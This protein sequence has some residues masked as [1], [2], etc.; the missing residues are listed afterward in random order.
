MSYSV[1]NLSKL[2]TE[3]RRKFIFK[4]YPYTR[5]YDIAEELVQ[6]AFLKAFSKFSQY[7]PEKGSLKGWFV[8]ILFTSLWDHMR[9]QK[10][11]P[12]MMHIDTAL[13]AELSSYDEEA[14]LAALLQTIKNPMHKKVLVSKLMFGLSYKEVASTQGV[15]EESVRKIVERFRSS[16]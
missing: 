10:K 13:E 7:N 8:K 4:I 11:I 12:Y 6:E 15:K 9:E 3:N 5:S 2:Y 14:D 16:Q 1:M